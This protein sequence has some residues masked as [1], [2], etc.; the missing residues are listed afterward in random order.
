[1]TGAAL[2]LTITLVCLISAWNIYNKEKQFCK[3]E[4]EWI[5][6]SFWVVRDG[7][8]QLVIQS[9]LVVGDVVQVHQGDQCPADGILL[10]NLPMKMDEQ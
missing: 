3:F 9:E 8:E 10:S 6:K 7:K 2:I 5:E 4:S 1:M